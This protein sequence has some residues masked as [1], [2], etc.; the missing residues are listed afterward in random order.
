MDTIM[1][2]S[3]NLIEQAARGLKPEHIAI[4]VIVLA[5]VFAVWGICKLTHRVKWF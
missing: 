5:A 1:R 2:T 3:G 4:G